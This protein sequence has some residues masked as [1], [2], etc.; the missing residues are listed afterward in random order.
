MPGSREENFYTMNYMATPLHKN[1]CPGVMKFTILLDPSLVIIT[2]HHEIYN[3]FCL[4]A[5][6]MLNTQFGQDL[7]SSS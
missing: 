4:L 3:F 5:L 2:I 1:F 7:S 6:Q